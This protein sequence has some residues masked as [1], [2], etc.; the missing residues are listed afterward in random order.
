M[1]EAFDSDP[2]FSDLDDTPPAPSKPDKEASP[3]PAAKAPDKVPEK[4]VSAAAP[5]VPEG[6]DEF[7][8]PQ[9][10]ALIDTRNWGKRMAN[11]AR[12]AQTKAKTLEAKVQELEQRAPQVPPDVQRIQQDYQ[13]LQQE[14]QV[15]RERLTRA[16]YSQSPEYEEKYKAPYHQAYMRGR[17]AVSGLNVRE[18]AGTDDATGEP[19][20]TTRPGTADDFDKLYNMTDSEADAAAESMFGPS[21]RRVISLRD[22]AKERA[23]QAFTAIKENTAKFNQERQAQQAQMQ[24]RNLSLQSLWK[25]VN[26][27]LQSKHA[28]WF[29]DREDDTAWNTDLAKGREIAK[30]RFSDAYAKM[31]PEQRVV[32]DGQIFNRVA[33]FTP[34]KAYITRIEAKHAAEVAELNKTIEQLRGSAPGKSAPGSAEVSEDQEAS[35]E[36]EGKKRNVF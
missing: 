29:G 11:M 17:T 15:H 19:K 9:S 10:A 35:W 16:D 13:R 5:K 20:F 24:Q 31:A 25:K 14:L 28:Q 21:A 27:D 30:Q 18:S 3:A 32:L 23:E 12:A 2:R 8:A 33:A 4:P 36:A 1:S 34:M 6:D 22:T 7:A 26:D